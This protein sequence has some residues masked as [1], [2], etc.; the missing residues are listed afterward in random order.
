MRKVLGFCLVCFVLLIGT[1]CQEKKNVP[2]A[3]A[4]YV[5]QAEI[6]CGAERYAA[7]LEVRGGGLFT[8]R[9]DEPSALKGLCFSFDKKLMTISF[10]GLSG[11]IVPA[12]RIGGFAELLSQVFLKLT[13]GGPLAEKEGNGYRYCTTIN[14]APL[15]VSV[16]PQG[17]P[18]SISLPQN[19]LLVDLSE[20]KENKNE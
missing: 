8:V 15:L 20:W 13:T 1:S 3:A 2:I 7:V 14:G 17:F 10:E 18:T 19:D 12:D 4:G 6:Q 11:T 16:N 5:C 9:V